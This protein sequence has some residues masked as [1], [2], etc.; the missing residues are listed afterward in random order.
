MIERAVEI[1]TPDGTADGFIYYDDD[2][3]K[4][5]GV[6]EL[7]DIRGI[8]PATRD[9]ARRLAGQGYVVLLP[10]VFYRSRRPPVFD[11][12]MQWGTERTMQRFA[13]LT[14]PITP[15]AMERDGAAYV[16]FLSQQPQVAAGPMGAVGY[17]FSGALALRTAAARADRVRAAASFHGGGLWSDQPTSPHLVLPRVKA[18]LLVGH[19]DQD[20]SM[21]AE[22]IARFDQA[23]A[24]W[25]GRF[26]SEVYPRAGHGWAVPDSPV[27]D[28]PQAERAFRELSALLERALAA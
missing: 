13:E 8:R 21:P 2:G 9:M 28:E 17:C 5:P 23:L 18:D 27:Y 12:E 6:V 7:T 26:T 3:K 11:F 25:G 16:E 20:R 22:S 15:E 1:P 10:N 19:A 14:G 24:A 4:R